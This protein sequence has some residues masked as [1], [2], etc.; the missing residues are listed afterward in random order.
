MKD[1]RNLQNQIEDLIRRGHLG[2]YLKEP[3]EVTPR[4]KGPVVRQ[5][6]VISRGPAASG[7]SSM[8]RKAYARSTM[9]KCSRSELE[10]EITFGAEE[11][12]RSYHDDALVI[13]IRIANARVKRVMVDTGSSAN[14]LYLDDFK[15]LSLIKEDLTASH[16]CP[17]SQSRE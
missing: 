2:H 15:K 5:I 17:A 11:V 12:E 10:P 3:R 8:A 4:P 9:E 7:N 13:S 1:C 16:R 6:D 14:V